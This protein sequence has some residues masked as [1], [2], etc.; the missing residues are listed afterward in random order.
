MIIHPHILKTAA[1]RLKNALSSA[2]ELSNFD[3][4]YLTSIPERTTQSKAN[5]ATGGLYP[6]TEAGTPNFYGGYGYSGS[7]AGTIILSL[8]NP[9]SGGLNYSQD[10]AHISWFNRTHHKV[11][12]GVPSK[13]S[14]G[15]E[16]GQYDGAKGTWGAS[17]YADNNAYLNINGA[18]GVSFGNLTDTRGWF[19]GER[20][21][22]TQVKLYRDGILINTLASVSVGIANQPFYG[23]ATNQSGAVLGTSQSSKMFS[24]VT[25]GKALTSVSAVKAIIDQFWIDLGFPLKTVFG[26]GDSVLFGFN[27]STQDFSHFNLYCQNKHYDWINCGLSGQAI[28]SGGTQTGFNTANII[29]KAASPYNHKVRFNWG[30]NDTFNYANGSRSLAQIQAGAETVLDA[31]QTAGWSFTNDMT[32]TGDYQ[33]ATNGSWSV[34]QYQAVMTVIKAVCAA[35]GIPFVSITNAATY[36]HADGAHPDANADYKKIADYEIENS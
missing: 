16:L 36:N 18:A 30:M 5:Q 6:A 32:Y 17:G 27:A 34:A 14:Q 12:S 25:V 35:R 31:F 11:V 9:A 13:L 20:T 2:G 1:L 4:I 23:L 21:N 3:A 8:I 24:L 28:A 10:N 33:V 7:G 19:Y 15:I 29:P 22:N 26:Y